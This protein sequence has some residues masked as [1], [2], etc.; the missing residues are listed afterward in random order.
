MKRAVPKWPPGRNEDIAK[1][2]FHRL[3]NIKSDQPP[4]TGHIAISKVITAT[5]PVTAPIGI[6]LGLN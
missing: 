6:N 4:H 3:R 5:T 2:P 1:N